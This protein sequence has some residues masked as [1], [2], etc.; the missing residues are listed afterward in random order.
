MNT[1]EY[2]LAMAPYGAMVITY[3]GMLPNGKY[4]GKLINSPYGMEELKI[5]R[6]YS[7][8]IMGWM[9]KDHHYL[10]SGPIEFF[11]KPNG[12]PGRRLCADTVVLEFKPNERRLAQDT[13][14]NIQNDVENGTWDPDKFYLEARKAFADLKIAKTPPPSPPRK[15]PIIKF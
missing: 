12:E 1:E 4:V 14:R 11:N 8:D 6:S 7:R 13:S 15:P 3:G 2:W 10:V 5:P 9:D